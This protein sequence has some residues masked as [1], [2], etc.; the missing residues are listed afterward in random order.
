MLFIEKYS[1]QISGVL[2]CYD[3]IVIQGTIPGI[4][5]AA[6]MTS[7]LYFKGIRIFD[8]P[9]FAAPF[10][11]EIRNNAKKIASDNGI[12]IQ[13]IAKRN[14]RKEKIIETVIK[15][16][17]DHPG[18]VHILSAM[19]S[20]P[21][22]KPWHNKNTHKTYLKSVQ[23]KC[24]HYYF[25]FIDEDL[26]L[27][28]V[29]VPT[30][31]PF[32]LQIYFNGHNVLNST[33]KKEG[34]QNVMLDNAILKTDSFESAQNFSNA[35]NIEHIHEKLDEFANFYCPVIKHFD[36]GYHWSIMQ[37]EYATD[38]IFKRQEDLKLI[39]ENLTR[40]AIHS[41]KPE[42]IA[43][44]LGRKLA[45]Q[46]QG[47]MGNNFSTRIEGTCVKFR[48]GPTSIKMYD[49]HGIILRIETTTNDI[50]FFK[51]YRKVE[52][53]DG[54]TSMKLAKIK[55]GLYSMGPLTKILFSANKRFLN[56]LADIVNPSVGIKKLE[57]ISETVIQNNRPFKG[58]NFFSQD[59][60]KILQAVISGEFTINGF[61]NKTLRNK[62][63]GYSSSQISRVLKRLHTHGLIKKVA[64][65]YK[66]YLTRLGSQVI[67]MGI[68][69]KSMV[70]IPELA[71]SYE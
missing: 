1:N 23:G 67:T 15:E 50:S 42:N 48:M 4:C 31:C 19:E 3:R 57:K 20:C 60:I 59:D 21:S 25:Y 40:T 36:F 51:H 28:Y 56:F 13:F 27:C 22:Y 38:I 68:K 8:Y 12:D 61:Q 26:G 2:H 14:I 44:F 34:L 6:G 39:Y 5:Y 32:R 64:K 37:I 62:L 24:L 46:Y 16:R 71:N 43:T 55:K 29:R 49:K 35:F 70:I 69:L 30:W 54:T 18:L 41:V 47:E 53:R 63:K 7:Y 9:Q 52:H 58:F 11:E 17:G 66:Y 65:T 10:K 45:P 33:M